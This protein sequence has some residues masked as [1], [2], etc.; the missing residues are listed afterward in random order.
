MNNTP[1]EIVDITKTD[2]HLNVDLRVSIPLSACSEELVE[3]LLREKKRII[4]G[5]YI[6]S[7]DHPVFIKIL[8]ETF[9]TEDGERLQFT[10]I[11][12]QLDDVGM[13]QP[14]KFVP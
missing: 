2:T 5:S 12:T 14:V 6:E 3:D 11:A 1:R 13:E 4:N 9:N 8:C 7:N 10:K